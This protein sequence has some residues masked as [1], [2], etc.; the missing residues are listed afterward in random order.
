MS[1]PRYRKP[2]LNS[3]PLALAALLLAG[4]SALA[5][6]AADPTRNLT[7]V[8]DAVLQNPPPSDW[9][10][11]RRTFDGY[12]YSPLDQINRNSVKDLQGAWTRSLVPG[13]T[14]TAPIVHDA[15]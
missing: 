7:P 2:P 1:V 10:M 3:L 12:G 15:R 5:P 13:A 4:T 14:Q 9:L 11:W 6:Q 8:P